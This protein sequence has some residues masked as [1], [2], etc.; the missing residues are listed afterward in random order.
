MDSLKGHINELWAASSDELVTLLGLSALQLEKSPSE[1]L[2]LGRNGAF[3]SDATVMGFA[4]ESA[5]LRMVGTSFLTRWRGEIRAAICGNRRLL[6]KE[7]ATALNEMHVLVNSVVV[8]LTTHITALAP[9]SGLILILSVMIVRSGLAAYCG[10]EPEK[11]TPAV[12]GAPKTPGKRK[13]RQA[14]G[15]KRTRRRNGGTS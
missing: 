8:A 13:T 15:P 4:Y 14:A 11:A 12:P 7:R 9:F 5:E 1:V 2:R 3:A 10:D 6:A